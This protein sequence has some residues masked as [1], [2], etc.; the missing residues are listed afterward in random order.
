MVTKRARGAVSGSVIERGDAVDRRMADLLSSSSPEYHCA[1]LRLRGRWELASVL[2]F[3]HV[4]EPV[5]RSG[6]ELSAE[7]IETA[8]ITPDGKLSKLHIALLRGIPPASKNLKKPDAWVTVLYRRLAPWWP[9]VAEG[10]IPFT[11]A[12]GQEIAKYKELNSTARLLILKA[13]C[14]VRAL[15]DDVLT[16]IDDAIKDGTQL[17][18]FQ[19]NGIAGDQD[20]TVYWYDGD[21]IIGHRL[22]KEITKIEFKQN[23]EEKCQRALPMIRSEWETLATN[24]EEFCKIS[25]KF[26]TC[27]TVVEAK[28]G[29]FV[30]NHIVPI[31]EKLE[32][33]KERAIKQQQRQAMLLNAFHTSLRNG[34]PLRGLKPISYTFDEYDR[35]IDEAI[36]I[37]KKDVLSRGRCSSLTKRGRGYDDMQEDKN[38][39]DD[40][41][42]NSDKGQSGRD[43]QAKETFRVRKSRRIAAGQYRQKRVASVEFKDQASAEITPTQSLQERHECTSECVLT[44]EDGKSSKRSEGHPLERLHVTIVLKS[45]PPS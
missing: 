26:S 5:I 15:Q 44:S 13:L 31:L 14:E 43:T 12:H 21:S 37:S 39:V 1:R 27:G 8:L 28:V 6:L 2:N 45:R 32:K 3:L 16:Y 11:L 23:I 10:N 42:G 7:E 22:Y 38:E 29:E 40:R 18:N 25:E 17:S 4:F 20:G 36:K 24:L 41:L 30:A 35:S 19:K 33:K 34:R 9:W